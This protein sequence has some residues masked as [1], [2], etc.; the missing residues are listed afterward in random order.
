MI[1]SDVAEYT[2]YSDKELAWCQRRGYEANIGDTIKVPVS[3]INKGSRAR[4]YAKCDICGDIKKIA[5]VSYNQN[6]ANQG[7]YCCIKCKYTKDKATNLLRYGTECTLQ[8]ES[9][10]QKGIETSMRK[11]GTP[12][13]VSSEECQ[14]R[15]RESNMKRYGV[16]YTASLESVRE[17]M[18][19]TNLERY[20]CE[21]TGA[22]KIVQEKTKK[23][24]LKRYGCENVF[25]NR[26][27]YSR[28]AAT[29]ARQM[30]ESNVLTSSQQRHIHEVYGGVMNANI[31]C[32]F[33]DILMDNMV[34]FEYDGAGHNISVLA[35][36]CTQEEF[37]L[38][39]EKRTNTIKSLGYREFRMSS[40]YDA[41]PS[42]E[43]LLALAEYAYLMF[44]VGY[45]SVLYDI[46]SK[47]MKVK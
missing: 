18:K 5:Y 15:I 45:T 38:R 17:K 47:V 27:I 2:V 29:R 32:Y 20:G 19:A 23:T 43:E 6:I 31:D 21:Y 41:V 26:E 3:V 22:S 24:N 40:P 9:V 44:D 33:V 7:F 25:S 36:F 11:Y 10:K 30:S 28:A 39:Q 16:A 1:I 42:D 14:R 13:P 12:V 35:H 37:D 4:V 34:F 8:N 46:D